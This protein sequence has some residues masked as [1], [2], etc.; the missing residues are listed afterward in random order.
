MK[1]II[2]A[3]A[4]ITGLT[5]MANAQQKTVKTPE[6]KAAHKAQNLQTKLKLTASQTKQVNDL[7]LKEA[8]RIDSL[9]AHK[10]DKKAN[11]AAHKAIEAQT[12]QKL[13]AIL[14]ADQKKALADLK[15]A[16]KEKHDQKKA[17]EAA[18]SKQ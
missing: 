10:T 11:K 4:F 9:K 3:I 14:T 6:Q 18:A 13:D 1:R 5:V 7:F 16:K 15:A 2:L 12:D 8:T 17:A